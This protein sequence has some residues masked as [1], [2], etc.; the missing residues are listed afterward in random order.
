MKRV[1]NAILF[2]NKF[3]STIPRLYTKDFSEIKEDI[4]KLKKLKWY[5]KWW[6]QLLI[7]LIIAV[8]GGVLLALIL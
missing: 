5:Q 1:V 2:L 4:Q 7:G 8:L 3:M 6:G